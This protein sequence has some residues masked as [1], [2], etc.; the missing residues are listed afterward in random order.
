MITATY[1]LKANLP[2]GLP[3]ERREI[4]QKS[5]YKNSRKEGAMMKVLAFIIL[6]LALG[7]GDR[8]A[9]Q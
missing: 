5:I 7:F 1:T 9:K 4:S 3:L 6:A 2:I 8:F